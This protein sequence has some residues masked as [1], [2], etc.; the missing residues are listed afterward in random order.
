MDD[1]QVRD[2]WLPEMGAAANVQ[3]VTEDEFVEL[4]SRFARQVHRFCAQRSGDLDLAEDL[5]SLTFLE[6]WRLRARYRTNKCDTALPWLLGIAVN[7]TRNETRSRRR[8]AAVLARLPTTREFT[9]DHADEVVARL[10]A[11]QSLSAA[12][13]VIE[14]LP[15]RERDA[16]QL[17]SWAGLSHDQAALALGIPVGTVRSRLSRARRTMSK[18]MQE[19]D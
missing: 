1:L 17:V 11:Q 3:G 2:E 10:D 7:V 8:Y 18:S 12:K 13:A 14:R 6:A 4:F 9:A 19:S 5:L 15:A 16:V